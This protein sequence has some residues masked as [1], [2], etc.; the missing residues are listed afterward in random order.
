M[1]EQR[2]LCCSCAAL[3]CFCGLVRVLTI[4]DLDEV[5]VKMK[6]AEILGSHRAI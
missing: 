5:N 4:L 2:P 6:K 1:V 3:S